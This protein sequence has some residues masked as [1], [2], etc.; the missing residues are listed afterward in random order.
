MKPPEIEFANIPT[1]RMRRIA[2]RFQ[3]VQRQMSKL[4]E[5]SDS[6]REQA[7]RLGVGRYETVTVYTVGPT[8]VHEHPRKGY[9]AIRARY[10]SSGSRR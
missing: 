4:K 9:K 10:A 6:L 3:Q 8:T 1:N 2:I 5:E 7:V